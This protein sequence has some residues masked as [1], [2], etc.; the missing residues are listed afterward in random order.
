[1][2]FFDCLKE[3]PVDF[4]KGEKYPFPTRFSIETSSYCNRRCPFCPI[5]GFGGPIPR[6][7]QQLMDPELF[8]QVLHQLREVSFDGVIQF[9]LLNEPTLDKRLFSYQAETG[10]AWATRLRQDLPECTIYV[11]TN[12]DSIMK[13]NVQGDDDVDKCDRITDIFD[14]GVNVLNLNVYDTGEEGV[15]QAELY[16]RVAQLGWKHK[17]WR[18]TD[19]KYRRHNPRQ[20]HLCVSDM[21]TDRSESEVHSF[22]MFHKK[23]HG[24]KKD[25]FCARP[26][27]HFVIQWDGR[28]PLCCAIDQTRDD[29]LFVGDLNTQTIEEVWNSDVMFKYRYHLQQKK[30]DLSMCSTCDHTMAYPHVVRKVTADEGTIARWS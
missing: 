1:M 14:S 21:R 6:P 26:H 9:F 16:H 4:S 19:N 23:T 27:R 25:A 22:D 18:F 7:K 15:A 12:G 13:R 28:V 10:A 5:S 3:P 29:A 11:S 20:R 30:R 2:G 24:E 17:L 8:S